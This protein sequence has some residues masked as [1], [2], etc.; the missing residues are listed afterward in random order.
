MDQKLI[1]ITLLVKLGVAAAVASAVGRSKDFKRLL[2]R[3]ERSFGQTVGFLAFM[4]V[5][6]GLGVIV[7]QNVRNFLAADISF[8]SVI[9]MGVMGGP[10]TGAL[11]GVLVGAPA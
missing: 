9:I 8:E 6:I 5:P 1:L 10:L 7:R 4:A 2:F 11:F 3:D